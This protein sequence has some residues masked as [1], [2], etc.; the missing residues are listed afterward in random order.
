VLCVASAK[1]HDLTCSERSKVCNC[2][3]LEFAGLSAL[4]WP[5]LCDVERA[6][7][8]RAREGVQLAGSFCAR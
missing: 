7:P 5:S 6:H 4:Q 3:C 1:L 8:K 2:C